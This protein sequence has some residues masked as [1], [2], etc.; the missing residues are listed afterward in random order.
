VNVV[1]PR[2]T[3]SGDLRGGGITPT[4]P[5][6]IKGEGFN[7]RVSVGRKSASVFRHFRC[8][9]RWR[10]ALRFSALLLLSPTAAGADVF[11]K[12]LLTVHVNTPVA[13]P[14]PGQ[15]HE[16]T[17]FY[18]R[19]LRVKQL[20]LGEVGAAQL[21][22]LP[23]QPGARRI[24]CKEKSAP[25]EIV[26]PA[27]QWSGYFAGVKGDWAFFRAEDG[28]DG[29]LGFAV[30]DGHTGRKLFDDLAI[31][32]IGAAAAT[33]R[34]L[35]LHYRRAVAGKCSIP[36]AGSRCWSQ[37]V[38][39]LP[40]L[41]ATPIPDCAAGY[42]KTKTAMAR[43]RCQAQSS[44]TCFATQMHLLD[45]QHWNDAPSVVAYDAVADIGPSGIA[46]K[47]AGGTL[48]CWPSD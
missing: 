11:D 28:T 40:G 32:N 3:P 9:P 34:G 44:T 38:A 5:S 25:G 23:L 19:G 36:A 10:N 27:S 37:I 4:Q 1:R 26:I 2:G 13:H 29:G 22:L 7:Q 21:A 46:I 17:C 45:A 24:A 18:Y 8:R 43:D 16:L 15:K 42:L 20:D 31:G 12:P 30:F 14:D 41:P 47:P 33:A 6:P 48:S 35:Q 39:T